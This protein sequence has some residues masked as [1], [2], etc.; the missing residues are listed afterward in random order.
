LRKEDDAGA[1]EGAC[2]AQ[3]NEHIVKQG[4]NN[5]GNNYPVASVRASDQNDAGRGGD[6]GDKHNI[7]QA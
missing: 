3:Y 1:P 6:K 4:P 2:R 7:L 5:F